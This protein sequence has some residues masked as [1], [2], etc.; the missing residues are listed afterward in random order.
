MLVPKSLDWETDGFNWPLR[1]NSHLKTVSD[2]RWHWQR[3]D[4]P[5]K[6]QL[7][8]LHGTGASAHTWA[9]LIPLLT[10]EFDILALDLP[11]Q[12]FSLCDE[13]T[14][15]SMTGMAQC[16]AEL[17]SDQDFEPS[18]VVGHSAGAA[19]AARMALQGLIS[20]ARI[21]AIAPA[22]MPWEGIAQ[23]LFTP[24]AKMLAGSSIMPRLFSRMSGSQES[25]QRLISRI[26]SEP[27]EEMVRCYQVLVGNEV[28]VAN[29]LTMMARWDLASL[30]AELP[31]LAVPVDL[32]VGAT[33]KAVPPDQARQ[34]AKLIPHARM[35]WLHGKGHLVHEEQPLAVA[36]IVSELL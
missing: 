29:T 17:I 28:H 22:L 10:P 13:L 12:A 27:I 24:M 16:V 26:G 6:P 4:S 19:L 36:R 1:A 8:L 18:V 23:H 14:K 15:M 5:A 34:A 7:L 30:T 2:V 32:V 20:P 35:H 3:F 25:V 33:D 21:I 31:A 11:G 9:P